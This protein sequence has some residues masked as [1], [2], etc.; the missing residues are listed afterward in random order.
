MSA[1]T[2]GT[3]PEPLFRYISCKGSV[4]VFKR[5]ACVVSHQ[6][7]NVSR[8]SRQSTLSSKGHNYR[9]E[10]GPKWVQFAKV[11]SGNCL[12]LISTLKRRQ[13]AGFLVIKNAVM[14]ADYLTRRWFSYES[15][16]TL[17]QMENCTKPRSVKKALNLTCRPENGLRTPIFTVL[18]I[19][20]VRIKINSSKLKYRV[21]N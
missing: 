2:N 5:R 6:V 12:N 1:E 14:Y 10:S 21:A 18:F 7:T 17:S 9:D 20:R 15:H 8:H 3:K 13:D 4:V 11:K 19:V 16:F